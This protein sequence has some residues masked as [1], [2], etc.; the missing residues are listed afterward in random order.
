[1]KSRMK[2]Y[3]TG[4]ESG[5]DL[6]EEDFS[7]WVCDEHSSPRVPVPVGTLLN[8]NQAWAWF[9]HS[10]I[11]WRSKV[12]LLKFQE[13]FSRFA[14]II[15]QLTEVSSPEPFL[16]SW[17]RKSVWTTNK[18]LTRITMSIKVC[19]LSWTASTR[20]WLSWTHTWTHTLRVALSSWWADLQASP[21]CWTTSF[22][23]PTHCFKEFCEQI[24]T[25]TH[26]GQDQSFRL[27]NGS[28]VKL[29][30]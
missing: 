27:A 17:M 14:R 6:E 8:G 26:T 16:P 24:H 11:W 15:S 29:R 21:T 30:F 12:Q 4:A 22:I 25:H 19:R 23:L 5:D 28:P 9:E 1:M 13:T 2:D 18:N 7:K 3:D 20:G 10:K